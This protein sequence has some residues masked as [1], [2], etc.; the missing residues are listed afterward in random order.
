MKPASGLPAI[1]LIAVGVVAFA[2]AGRDVDSQIS[3]YSIAAT[4]AGLAGALLVSHR[5]GL[6]TALASGRLGPWASLTFA[7]VFGLS[8]LQW[9]DAQS[10]VGSGTLVAESVADALALLTIAWGVWIL[11]YNIGALQFLNRPASW[12]VDIAIPPESAEK[13][14]R[15][16]GVWVLLAFS[17]AGQALSTTTNSFGYL[18]DASA[19]VAS[20]S[21]FAQMVNVLSNMGLFAVVVAAV[22]YFSP[23]RRGRLSTLVVVSATQV[24]LAV[25]QGTKEGIAIVAVAI[26]LSYALVRGRVNARLLIASVVLFTFV[27]L[28]F[29][30]TY[31]AT[32]RVEG[33]Q[34]SVAT[35]IRVLPDVTQR[36]ASQSGYAESL[37]TMTDR[38]RNIDSLAI[39]MQRSPDVVPY[40]PTTDLATQSILG[41]VP[42]ILW[43]NKPNFSQGYAFG[44]TYYGTPTT[45]YSSFATTPPADL[46]RHGGPFVLMIGMV[47][48]GGVYRLFDDVL[49]PRTDFRHMFVIVAMFPVLVKHEVDVVALLLSVPLTLVG[50][51]VAVRTLAL[52]GKR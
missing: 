51:A 21:S 30:T 29:V 3:C 43:P 23:G 35:A 40:E 47:L 4:S 41:L 13:E 33:Q 44:Q 48:L 18:A 42:R 7:L 2:L 6:R 50:V 46:Y 25:L 14:W 31:R 10:D 11:G 24:A 49:H 52:V 39:V 16:S 15:S 37:D 1:G 8:S 9:V 34:T 27:V 20:F 19:S 45:L 28:P 36:T 32:V 5:T 38:L 17:L 26:I 12:I 22:N